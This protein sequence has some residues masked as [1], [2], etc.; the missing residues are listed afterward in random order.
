MRSIQLIVLIPL[1]FLLSGCLKEE[2]PVPA[3]PRGDAL[4]MQTCMGPGYQD[5][6]WIDLGTGTVV[7]TNPKTAWD[8]AIES[9][10]NGWRM[11]LNGSRMMTAWNIGPVSMAQPADTAG[12]GVGRRIDAPSGNPDSTAFGNGWGSGDVYIVD[13]GYNALGQQL[14]LLK[15]R[16]NTVTASQ[17]QFTTAALDGS[18]LQDHVVA[19]DASRTYTYFS[20]ASGSTVTIEPPKGE[21]DMVLTQY[22]H[23][24]YTPFLPYI[25]AGILTDPSQVRVARIPSASY[26]EVTLAD[27]LLHPFRQER[28]TIGYDWKD[29]SF[30]LS[31]YEVFPQ[32]VYIV[33]NRA[34]FRYKLHFLDFYSSQGVVGCPTF[35]FEEL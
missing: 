31:V 24:F 5:Q 16:M 1:S 13:L 18:A 23:Q 17:V 34:G 35:E 12:M 20:F 21:W 10:A 3:R 26:N 14:G 27:T 15:L 2:L 25:V 19:K 22:T 33:E 11:L 28:N 32:I 9:D 29:Y 4:T 30:D 6:V 8:L 7:S